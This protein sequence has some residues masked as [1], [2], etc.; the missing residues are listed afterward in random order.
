MANDLQLE[1]RT[2]RSDAGQVVWQCVLRDGDTVITQRVMGV[3]DFITLIKGAQR[4]V[5]TATT[6]PI[7]MVPE[8]MVTGYTSTDASTFGAIIRVP[9]QK[10]QFVL[11]ET[12]VNNVNRTSFMTETTDNKRASFFLPMPNLIYA[13][14]VK[15]GALN[16]L[17][18]FTYKEWCGEDTI[19]YQ[20]PFGNVS[21][22]GSVCMG[23]VSND[24]PL[25]SCIDLRNVIEASLDGETNGDYLTYGKVRLAVDATQH[26]F[27]NSIKDDDEFP[28]HLL[29]EHPKTTTVKQLI[30]EHG[31]GL[32]VR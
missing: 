32:R 9:A 11:A 4:S 29:L 24:T 19:L 20:Y 28:H 26:D 6:F 2:L 1:A 25:R 14:H 12:G 15:D 13:G 5:A 10:H 31:N 16:A 8:G 30:E 23:T 22:S 7:G 27:C 17:Y 3:D 21:S 18:C